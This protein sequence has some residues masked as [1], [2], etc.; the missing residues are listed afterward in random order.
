LIGLIVDGAGDYAAFRARWPKG[1][2]VLKTDGPRGHTVLPEAI[3]SSA[4]KQVAILKALGCT[5]A[6]IVTDSE[7]RA[8]LR[9]AEFLKRLER[10][11]ESTRFELSVAI[12]SPNMMIENWYLADIECLCKHK[13][14]LKR[15]VR[16]RCFEGRHGKKELRRLFLKGISYNEVDHGP[17]LF[18]LIRESVAE[19]NSPSFRHFAAIAR[20]RGMRF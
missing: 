4:A 9:Y 17:E 11:V 7:D 19:T 3:V 20:G 16:Q 15:G 8:G 12:A 2:R 18:P 6:I 1:V 14:F 10:S 13:K 5:A